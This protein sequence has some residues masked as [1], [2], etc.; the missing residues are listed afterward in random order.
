MFKIPRLFRNSK[1]KK[2]III[3][4]VYNRGATPEIH[5]SFK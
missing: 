2:G 1:K 4:Y 3:D 5:I